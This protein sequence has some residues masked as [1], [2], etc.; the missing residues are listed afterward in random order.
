M[1]V[2]QGKDEV[3]VTHGSDSVGDVTQRTDEVEV[4]KE[5][6]EWGKSLK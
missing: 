1:E 6:I 4:T 3:E 2:I 5:L